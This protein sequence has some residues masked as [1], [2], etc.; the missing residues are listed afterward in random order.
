M[1]DEIRELRQLLQNRKLSTDEL[2]TLQDRKLHFIIRHAYENVP[3]YHSLLKKTGLVPE[4]IRTVEDLIHVPITTKDDLRVAGMQRIIARS[5]KLS[6]CIPLMTSGT[7]GKRFTTY[8]TRS[9]S[10]TR[11][12]V[13]FRTLLSIGYRPRDYLAVLGSPRPHRTRFHQRLGFFRSENILSTLS[14][15]DQ[16]QRLYRIHPTMLWVRP[17]VLRSILHQVNYRLS[18]LVRPRVLIHNAEVFDEVIKDRSKL[19]Y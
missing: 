4:D 14:T 10:R 1:F 15:E 3:Y 2:K 18:Q 16:I 5:I 11:G 9:D 17:T 6:S 8:L 19:E 13:E 7:T 12:L